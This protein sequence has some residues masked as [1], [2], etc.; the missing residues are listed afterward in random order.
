MTERELEELNNVSEAIRFFKIVIQN[1]EKHNVTIIS[2][3]LGEICLPLIL[4]DEFKE[5]AC[6]Q[7]K[8]Y[9]DIFD[10]TEVKNHDRP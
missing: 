4:K 5:W 10:R 1:I 2:T 8:K 9:Q 3:P 6:A 7:L